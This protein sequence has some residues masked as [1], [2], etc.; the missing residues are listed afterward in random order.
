MN[1]PDLLLYAFAG[2]LV[3]L[4]FLT[5]R[6]SGPTAATPVAPLPQLQPLVRE[7]REQV[8]ARGQTL[9]ELLAEYRARVEAERAQHA[10]TMEDK[11]WLL[12][13]AKDHADTPGTPSPT[14]AT[15]AK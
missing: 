3:L 4:A 9:G 10:A 7:A 15:P 6:K 5:R 1:P 8:R 2:G 12:K 11:N 13:E 14:A